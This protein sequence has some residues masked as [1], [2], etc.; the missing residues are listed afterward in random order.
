MN[1]KRIAPISGIAFAVFFI[2]SIAASSVPSDS[3]S[4]GQWMAAYATHGKQ[5]QHLAT[6]VLLVLAGLSLLIFLTDLWTRA[7]GAGEPRARSP[8]PLVAAGTSAACI[9]VGG[10]MM[11]GISGAALIGSAPIPGADTLRLAN[12]LGFAMTALGGMLAAAIGICGIALQARAAGMF[13]AK[14]TRFTLGVAVLQ[15]AA[16]AFVPIILMAIWCLVVAVGLLRGSIP[17][18]ESAEG[19]R[20]GGSRGIPARAVLE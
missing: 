18:A 13:G 7:G 9:A 10:V 3:A 19:E 17:S 12:D 11:G 6:G 14:L 5:A 16:L 20:E 2:A 15:L 4:A 8:L 1:L